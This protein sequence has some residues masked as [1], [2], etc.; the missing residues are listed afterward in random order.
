VLQE[1]QPLLGAGQPAPLVGAFLAGAPRMSAR[2]AS[3][4]R[5]KAAMETKEDLKVLASQL[6]P[7]IG[8]WDPARLSDFTA[9]L[10]NQ[11]DQSLKGSEEETIGWIRHAEIKHGRVAMLAFVGYIVQANG[12]HWPWAVDYNGLTF[13]DISAAGSPPDQ[14]DALPTQAKTQFILF[15]GF[16]EWAGENSF[17]LSE[18]GEKHY[19]KGGRPGAYPSI[20]NIVHP[21]PL[22]FWDPLGFT[23]GMS[24]EKKAK[25][26]IAEINNGRLAML[27]IMAFL[28]EAKIPGSV[29]ALGMFDIPAYG[30]EV[31]APFNANDAGLPFVKR[32]LEVNPIQG[33]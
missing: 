2:A 32:M 15:I 11:Y 16:L 8:F 29:P 1:L 10:R 24:E 9:P 21:I 22:D 3:V 20:K 6:N 31:M 18:S 27:G 17:L 25:S 28:A 19:V 5:A 12:L 30:G 4:A 13:G 26:L 33:I 14:W 7:A 23:K